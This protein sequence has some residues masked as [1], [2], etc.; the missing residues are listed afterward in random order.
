MDRRWRHRR[1]DEVQGVAAQTYICPRQW[2]TP[3]ALFLPVVI[4][5]EQACSRKANAPRC[6]PPAGSGFVSVPHIE[7]KGVAKR[8][9]GVQALRDIDLAVQRGTIHGLVGENG[10]GK[11][12]L[13]KIISGVIEPDQG[14]LWVA[15]RAVA[16]R[17][18]R[19]ALAD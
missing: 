9:G 15:G 16:Y 10:A 6:T 1:H 8:F 14:Q 12:T 13:G 17:S 2:R 3:P 7:L 18:P 5:H 11:S 4:K 19:D